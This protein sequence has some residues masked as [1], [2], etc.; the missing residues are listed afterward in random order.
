LW[1]SQKDG[2]LT[3]EVVYTK[4]GKPI[5]VAGKVDGDYFTVYEFDKS[6]NITGIFSLQVKG[7]SLSGT[8]Y[9]PQNGKNYDFKSTKAQSVR[10]I[11]IDS[12]FT[13][14]PAPLGRYR[15]SFGEEKGYGEFTCEDILQDLVH[16]Q[17]D[18]V[19]PA[20]AFHIAALDDTVAFEL[21]MKAT[22][23]PYSANDGACQFNITF[24][25]TFAS[26]DYVDNKME[27]DFGYNAHPVGIY[28]KV[29]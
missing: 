19:T 5:K 14:K 15:Y 7:D 10:N 1:L 21:G 2:F 16:L 13:P 27:C 24:F 3:G 26:I 23:L 4:S 20:P 29:K 18:A 6:G 17:L 8:W 9:S 22:V 11:D 28:C 25:D 12:L